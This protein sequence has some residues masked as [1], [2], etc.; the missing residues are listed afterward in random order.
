MPPKKRVVRRKVVKKVSASARA[1]QVQKQT[2]IIQQPP[3][4]APKKRR[5]R[6]VKKEQA[7][8]VRQA[9]PTFVIQNAPQRDTQSDYIRLMDTINLIRQLENQKVAEQNMEAIQNAKLMIPEAVQTEA[10]VMDIGVTQA[11]KP[12]MSIGTQTEEPVPVP[13]VKPA[14]ATTSVQTEKVKGRLTKPRINLSLNQIISKYPTA[15]DL[16]RADIY[17][18]N[19]RD[20]AVSRGL[21]KSRAKKLKKDQLIEYLYQ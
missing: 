14:Q 1:Q 16:R 6:T 12:F 21:S 10:P 15:D 4:E 8:P 11:E 17:I 2:V 19:I 3:V 20:A 7:V 5:R 9:A 13:V 18:D